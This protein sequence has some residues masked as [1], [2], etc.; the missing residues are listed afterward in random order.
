MAGSAIPGWQE[1][2][3][4]QDASLAEQQKAWDKIQYKYRTELGRL[5][6]S[7]NMVMRCYQA[8]MRGEDWTLVLKTS[9]VNQV[10]KVLALITLFPLMLVVPLTTQGLLSRIDEGLTGVKPR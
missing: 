6:L 3:A 10:L 7:D 5:G 1:S 9:S 4:A 2:V 8:D